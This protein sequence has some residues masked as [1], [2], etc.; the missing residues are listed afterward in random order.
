MGSIVELHNAITEPSLGTVK[1]YELTDTSFDYPFVIERAIAREGL[2]S[3]DTFTYVDSPSR[4]SDGRL[5]DLS[6]QDGFIVSQCKV[7]LKYFNIQKVLRI[8]RFYFNEQ[9]ICIRVLL[10]NNW[11]Y[12]PQTNVH[13]QSRAREII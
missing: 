4:L 12:Y 1:L 2:T 9:G 10:R 8:M 13:K 5:G 3:F 6:E 7:N 11:F